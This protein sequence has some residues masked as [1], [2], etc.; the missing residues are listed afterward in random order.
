LER[1]RPNRDYWRM[2]LLRTPSEAAFEV[3]ARDPPI[4]ANGIPSPLT[5]N[6]R[7]G[8]GLQRLFE[9]IN[10]DPLNRLDHLLILLDRSLSDGR[11]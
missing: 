2:M 9:P 8:H 1:L 6:S 10:D 3:V 4:T 7:L 11:K 5:T